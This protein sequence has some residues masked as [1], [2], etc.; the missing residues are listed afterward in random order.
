MVVKYNL[1]LEAFLHTMEAWNRAVRV[2]VLV[3]EKGQ[4]S[5]SIPET[6]S[7]WNCSFKMSTMDPGSL[8]LK[9]KNKNAPSDNLGMSNVARLCKKGMFQIPGELLNGAKSGHMPCA[10]PDQVEEEG[11]AHWFAVVGGAESEEK[12]PLPIHAIRRWHLI[13]DAEVL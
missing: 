4:S 7:W 13:A 12:Q 9:N 3:E 11:A 6:V 8:F 10:L 1:G 2:S 5:F